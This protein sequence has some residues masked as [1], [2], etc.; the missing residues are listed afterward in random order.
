M[1]IRAHV[2]THAHRD[3]CAKHAPDLNF[4]ET[5]KRKGMRLKTMTY[6]RSQNQYVADQRF[7]ARSSNL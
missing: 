5:T 3:L 4:I 2:H 1:C 6:P 7:E